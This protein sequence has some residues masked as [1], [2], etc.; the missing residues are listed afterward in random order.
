MPTT[1]PSVDDMQRTISELVAVDMAAAGLSVSDLAIRAGIP[2][3]PLARKLASGSF[4]M[5]ELGRLA[6]VLGRR[7]SEWF[8]IAEQQATV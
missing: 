8:K 7:P 1:H 6:D 3:A 4:R 5:G 2:R